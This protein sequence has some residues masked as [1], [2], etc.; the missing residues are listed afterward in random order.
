MTSHL[1]KSGF[2]TVAIIKS[3]HS[4]KKKK[5]VNIEETI[6]REISNLIPTSE[7]LCSAPTGTY[8][9]LVNNCGELRM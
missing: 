5:K 7:K 2:G 4:K 9:L 1:C 6:R 8:I 3:K